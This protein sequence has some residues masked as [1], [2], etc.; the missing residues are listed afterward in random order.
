MNVIIVIMNV[1]GIYYSNDRN[2]R[3]YKSGWSRS[4][5]QPFTSLGGRDGV[6]DK[7]DLGGCLVLEK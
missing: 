7:K 2:D 5:E 3:G 6:L 1:Y 4:L